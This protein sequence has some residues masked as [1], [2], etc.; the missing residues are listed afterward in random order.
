MGREAHAAQVGNHDGVGL[1]ERHG[2]R[3]P[4]VAGFAIAMQH[5]HA[6]AMPADAH[7][8]R[9]TV[10]GHHLGLEARRIGLDAGEG[11]AREGD[12]GD[13]RGD[14]AQGGDSQHVT[15]PPSRSGR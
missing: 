8:E 7:E 14:E 9:R 10:G 13:E 4:H 15:N 1:G 6:R 11:G 3:L 12:G 5:H 2:Q